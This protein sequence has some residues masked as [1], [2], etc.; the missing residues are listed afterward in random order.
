M[1]TRT[2]TSRLTTALSFCC[3]TRCT[4]VYKLDRCL[5]SEKNDC[6]TQGNRSTKHFTK[7]TIRLMTDDMFDVGDLFG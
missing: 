1:N 7:D 2:L 4:S 3:R 6:L 5:R